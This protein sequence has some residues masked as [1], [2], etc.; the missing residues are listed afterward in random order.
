MGSLVVE[1][2]GLRAASYRSGDLASA[3][4]SG[5][6]DVRG[7]GI[8]DTLVRRTG[9][10]AGRAEADTDHQICVTQYAMGYSMSIASY[11]GLFSRQ[12]NAR[13]R[14]T[15]SARVKRNVRTLAACI[16]HPS[17][18]HESGC[19]VRGL[20]SSRLTCGS[21]RC[22]ALALA[23]FSRMAFSRASWLASRLLTAAIFC[24]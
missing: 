16:I 10:S 15:N 1:W 22:A 23:S 5:R 24:C 3:R 19:R 6:A 14:A 2:Y 13:G 8:G 4:A 12:R 18:T 20:G 9:G 21:G 11:A 7:A 17:S